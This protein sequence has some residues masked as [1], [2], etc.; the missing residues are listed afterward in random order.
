MRSLVPAP[1]AAWRL[2]DPRPS[3]PSAWPTARAAASRPP[4]GR[5]CH[6]WRRPSASVAVSALRWARQGPQR[7]RHRSALPAS[8]RCLQSLR[9]LTPPAC[10]GG[11]RG[12]S[13]RARRRRSSRRQNRR[14]GTSVSFAMHM[15]TRTRRS[16]PTSAQVG[17]R[18]AHAVDS[19]CRNR[20]CIVRCSFRQNNA[21]ARHVVGCC[22][23][24]Q[25]NAT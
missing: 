2:A 9:W 13:P 11:A 8:R 7:R 15:Y 17:L 10:E 20:A 18:A 1:E 21:C 6:P 22:A 5:S 24:S 25:R 12:A 16:V 3:A 4:A 19:P 14:G 23:R